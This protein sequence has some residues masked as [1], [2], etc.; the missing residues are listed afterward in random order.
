MFFPLLIHSSGVSCPSF[1]FFHLIKFCLPSQP[2][3]CLKS[4]LPLVPFFNSPGGSVLLISPSIIPS[5]QLLV[6]SFHFQSEC[7]PNYIIL[8]PSL[9]YFKQ[10]VIFIFPLLTGVSSKCFHFVKFIFFTFH[11]QSKCCRN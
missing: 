3:C 5:S 6:N 10:S 9:S 11:V 2:E 8:F 7:C 4:F 1:K